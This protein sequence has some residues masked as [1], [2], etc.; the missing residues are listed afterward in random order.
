M[1]RGDS[2]AEELLSGSVVSLWFSVPFPDCGLRSFTKQAR[3]VGGTDADEGEWPW[4]VSLHAQ[5]QGH[6][7]GASLIS[8]KWLVSAAHCFMDDRNFK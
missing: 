1:P 3:V 4:Q 5:G 2:C 8:P 6:L 7:C